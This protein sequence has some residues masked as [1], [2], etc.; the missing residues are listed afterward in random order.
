[1]DLKIPTQAELDEAYALVSA[2]QPHRFPEKLSFKVPGDGDEPV[3]LH[4]ILGNPSGAC[5]A[6]DGSTASTAWAE[7]LEARMK[8]RDDSPAIADKLVGDCLLWPPKVQ[9]VA[10]LDRWP[11]LLTGLLRPVMRKCGA[12]FDLDK[13][14]ERPPAI[15]AALARHPR[16][17]WRRLVLQG[18]EI[19]IVIEPM[20]SA[21]W[22]M[23]TEANRKA[24]SDHWK[25]T[26]DA[27]AATVK[28]VCSEDP[29]M[30]THI[31]GLLAR[32]P[33]AVVAVI[34]TVGELA[35]IALEVDLGEA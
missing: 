6:Q 10:W 9:R 34:G 17:T 8:L 23:F 20:A 31:D 32:W 13:P 24:G 19:D 25:L 3:Q 21:P 7:T 15:A 2:E 30:P 11:A 18:H 16:A 12:S 27:A 29:K 26:K 5:E 22:R 14:K 28:E 4:V 33:G 35:G 1:M